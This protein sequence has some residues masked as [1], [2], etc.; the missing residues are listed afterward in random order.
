MTP[1]CLVLPVQADGGNSIVCKI[2]SWPS[3]D[4]VS[5]K[6]DLNTTAHLRIVSDHIHPFMPA[7]HSTSDG[8]FK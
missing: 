7:M 4:I 8:C 2:F 5:S 6:H 3:L 1:S